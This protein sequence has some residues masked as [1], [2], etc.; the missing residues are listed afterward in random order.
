MYSLY[1]SGSPH[2]SH[3]P[4]VF[5]YY[6]KKLLLYTNLVDFILRFFYRIRIPRQVLYCLPYLFFCHN[7]LHKQRL[8][9][10]QNAELG[11]LPG[12]S[13]LKIYGIGRLNGTV[14]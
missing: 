11:M 2:K 4:Y 13:T 6:H 5:L 14:C 8:Q 1:P 10:F 9:G 12:Q 3:L 7:S